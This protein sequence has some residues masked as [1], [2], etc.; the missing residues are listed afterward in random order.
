VRNL[1]KIWCFASNNVFGK[2][3][4]NLVGLLEVLFLMLHNNFG[5]FTSPINA[6]WF[7]SVPL[8]ATFKKATFDP[9]I[10]Y[11]YIYLFINYITYFY[12]GRVAQ[13]V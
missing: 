3:N 8:A 5:L 6:R 1:S 13:L 7:S 11:V 10:I 4:L 2:K 9:P 12:V